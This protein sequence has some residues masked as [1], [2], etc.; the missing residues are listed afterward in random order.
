MKAMNLQKTLLF[1]GTPG[2]IIFLMF[3]FAYPKLIN[4]GLPIW[5]NTYIC[6]WI[7]LIILVSI[8]ITIFIKSDRKIN[9][10]FWVNKLKRK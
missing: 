4:I 10:Y 9:D 7:P 1:F 5:W 6:L 2:L 3:K 8:I